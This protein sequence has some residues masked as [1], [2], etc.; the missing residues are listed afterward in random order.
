[1]SDLKKPCRE[2]YCSITECYEGTDS[3][4]DCLILLHGGTWEDCVFGKGWKEPEIK[5]EGD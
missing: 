3:E 5:F 4:S 2:D 1:M